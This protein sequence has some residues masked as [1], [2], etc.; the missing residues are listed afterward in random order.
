M[1]DT[2]NTMILMAD[3]DP[4]QIM[5]SEAALA[6]AGFVVHSVGDGADAVEQ[7]ERSG[8]TS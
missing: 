1:S 4:A 2:R 7:F 8:P 6:G 3:D 5:L